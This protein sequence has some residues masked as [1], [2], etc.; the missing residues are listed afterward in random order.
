MATKTSLKT[1]RRPEAVTGLAPIGELD[2]FG[3]P[4]LIYG[5]N[6]IAYQTLL[7]RVTA[8]VQANGVFEEIWV[9]DYVQLSWE[10]FRLRR[11]KAKL[12]AVGGS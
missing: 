9:Q 5:E 10:A 6:P 3:A 1:Q 8:E 2:F 7:T 4:S 12:A 11:L